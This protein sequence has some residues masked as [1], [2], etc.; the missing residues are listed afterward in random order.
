[1]YSREQFLELTLRECETDISKHFRF[2]DEGRVKL[3]LR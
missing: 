2:D 1:M 3:E